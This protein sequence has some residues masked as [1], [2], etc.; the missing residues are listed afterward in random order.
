MSSLQES[1]QRITRLMPL[2]DA[3][4]CIETQ[5]A[6][7]PAREVD[8]RGALGC[9]L[10]VNA[11]VLA[12]RPGAALALR[13]GYAVKAEATAGASSYSPVP[14][15]GAARA[16]EVGDRLPPDTDAVASP[17]AI[18]ASDSEIY[19]LAPIAPGDGILPAGADAEPAKPLRRAGD[20]L[21]TIDVAVLGA[22]GVARV[23]VRAPRVRIVP[24]RAVND[25]VTHEAIHFLDQMVAKAGGQV[26]VA[27]RTGSVPLEDVMTASADVVLIVGGSGGGKRDHSVQTLARVGKVVFHGVAIAP[28]ESAAFGFVGATPVLIL[29]GR[30]DAVVS[31]WVMLGEPLFAKL[32]GRLPID[33]A[34]MGVLARKV[35]S[36]IG[37]VEMVLVRREG[38]KLVPLP[39][40]YLSMQA[41]A[42]SD[43][44][45]SIPADRE[46]F[47][48]GAV[49][50]V[51]WWS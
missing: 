42:E 1:M 50:P 29:P 40:G 22:L 16:I 47:P 37:L 46:G 33:V 51:R 43:G 19:A 23:A 26:V 35:S 28:G 25:V 34:T 41:L 8:L 27:Q 13:D 20:T 49:V 44:L 6:A 11:V 4:Q 48:E 39:A 3:L 17:D 5:V 36:A 38:D 14:M 2:A 10:A 32:C 31:V 18:E 45:I 12:S 24:A 21:R 7:L 30:L 9:T 15:L